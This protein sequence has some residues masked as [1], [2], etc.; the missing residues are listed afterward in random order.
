MNDRPE[1]AAPFARLVAIMERLRGDSGCPWDRQQDERS[2][3]KHMGSEYGEVVEAVE[4]GDTASLREELG[5]LLFNIVFMARVAEEKGQFD[6][7][8]VARDI[9]DKLIRRHPHVF[10]NPRRLTIEEA[11]QLWQDLKA[12]EKTP[13]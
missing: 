4:A 12:Q 1:E 6:I 13:D 2:L 3:L 10:E 11:A 5:D 7:Q 9:G 8:D